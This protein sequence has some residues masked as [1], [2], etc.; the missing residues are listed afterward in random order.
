MGCGASSG[1]RL[2]GDVLDHQRS[3]EA[4]AGRRLPVPEVPRSRSA[5]MDV[6]Q[7][8]QCAGACGAV[9]GGAPK[10]RRILLRD[11]PVP[12][13][14]PLSWSQLSRS[15]WARSIAKAL[16]KQHQDGEM[17]H[18]VVEGGHPFASYNLLREHDATADRVFWGTT[19]LK[20]LPLSWRMAVAAIQRLRKFGELEAGLPIFD[21]D[22]SEAGVSYAE[23]I[24][25]LHDTG[26][27][28]PKEQ[29]GDGWAYEDESSL[30]PTIWPLPNHEGGCD[31]GGCV[32]G[33]RSPWDV[34]ATLLADPS[35][36][37]RLPLWNATQSF[38][39]GFA[40]SSHAHRSHACGLFPQFPPLPVHPAEAVLPN[41]R[42]VEQLKEPAYR[43][44]R[45]FVA[46]PPDGDTLAPRD[47]GYHCAARPFLHAP[48]S[49]L[50]VSI[51]FTQPADIQD[52][53][54]ADAEWLD[55]TSPPPTRPQ[56]GT[57]VEFWQLDPKSTNTGLK[58]MIDQVLLGAQ[59]I[60]GPGRLYRV[61]VTL[62]LSSGTERLVWQFRTAPAALY[63][64]G[65]PPTSTEDTTEE[66][67][68]QEMDA[69][70]HVEAGE[71]MTKPEIKAHQKA[72]RDDERLEQKLNKQDETERK[73]LLQIEAG[74][75]KRQLMLTDAADGLAD[76]RLDEA[77]LW[78]FPLA[79]ALVGTSDHMEFSTGDYVIPVGWWS[80][81][82]RITGAGA[83]G[84]SIT[85]LLLPPGGI[86]IS[87]WLTLEHVVLVQQEP[88][89]TLLWV[90]EESK[91]TLNDAKVVGEGARFCIG[92]NGALELN[93]VDF[94]EWVAPRPGVREGA[95]N[96]CVFLQAGATLRCGDGNVFS[97]PTNGERISARRPCVLAASPNCLWPHPA[98]EFESS[99]ELEQLGH[100]WLWPLP[101]LAKRMP[102]GWRRDGQRDESLTWPQQW[103]VLEGVRGGLRPQNSLPIVVASAQPGDVL[104]LGAG[105]FELP[106]NWWSTLGGIHGVGAAKTVLQLPASS[107]LVFCTEGECE[108]RD[109]TIEVRAPTLWAWIL[110]GCT[111]R[112]R[113][114]LLKRIGHCGG[115]GDGGGRLCV[116]PGGRLV[117][118]GPND[119]S[120]WSKTLGGERG[121]ALVEVL[122][123]GAVA[124]SVP[125][126]ELKKLE[127]SVQNVFNTRVA[128]AEPGLGPTTLAHA[129]GT[130]RTIELKWL[131]YQW[132]WPVLP[133]TDEIL[134]PQSPTKQGAE[135]QAAA[136]AV[137][138]SITNIRGEELD[139]NGE[140]VVLPK[141]FWEVSD[142]IADLQLHSEAQGRGP[143]S[144]SMIGKMLADKPNED[145]D[146][147]DKG[148]K[149]K[150][151]TD[152][153]G[154]DKKK[155]KRK[156]KSKDLESEPELQPES[157]PGGS[158]N[159]KALAINLEPEPVNLNLRQLEAKQLI[160]TDAPQPGERPP[161]CLLSVCVCPLSATDRHFCR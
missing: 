26:R 136:R 29:P 8:T 161:L 22:C 6:I 40:R 48:A 52:F 149:E 95:D 54:R 62:T 41:G 78:P 38:G 63:R 53:L 47:C 98:A 102:N 147:A 109:C 19:Q 81:Q 158:D 33:G 75:K 50:I 11:P 12:R 70:M 108:I 16:C 87:G 72:A 130:S 59:T 13:E 110:Q 18:E 69:E 126:T 67:D 118:E 76:D 20:R 27:S 104:L 113:G 140:V 150:E 119:W 142:G 49:G 61:A 148:Q 105:E 4:A 85:R 121:G 68:E 86:H 89:G 106:E 107:P 152:E 153:N 1:G 5:L 115:R 132:D 46:F 124:G 157:Q 116:A 56:S 2:S 135:P 128:E 122:R 21:H 159:T 129:V 155:R 66:V 15:G 145:G 28:P 146:S 43:C 123:G 39:V 24:C 23:W 100:G 44:P 101:H 79:M 88:A 36:R 77:D 125:R 64:I 90:H 144:S 114:T 42:S 94:R 55:V 137:A 14:P 138:S 30:P 71:E 80:R 133:P 143:D 82:R 45:R 96:V 93:S 84:A 51:I 112:F 65:P 91:L 127:P 74:K 25:D 156:Q 141:S 3:L 134:D 58:P 139:A 34:L 37:R 60:L 92:G 32:E 120:D 154:G 7:L 111:L 17:M 99:V 103:H 9:A 83:V 151:K 31:L 131:R 35:H 10:P 73:R 160:D 97:H 57:P 117:F